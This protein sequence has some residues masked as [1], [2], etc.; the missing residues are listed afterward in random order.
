MCDVLNQIKKNHK[1]LDGVTIR[2]KDSLA[3]WRWENEE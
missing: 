2:N 3:D 1:V